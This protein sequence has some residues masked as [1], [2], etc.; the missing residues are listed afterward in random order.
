MF[1]P[2]GI[3]AA[4]IVDGVLDNV[5]Y[6]LGLRTSGDVNRAAVYAF[7]WGLTLT[8]VSAVLSPRPWAVGLVMFAIGLIIRI[9]PLFMLLP[10]Q[11]ERLSSLLVE[12]A[13]VNGAHAWGGGVA[14]YLIR[15][16]AAGISVTPSV[17]Q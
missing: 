12:L 8:F 14:L 11:R 16:L 15:K 2:A 7:A 17:Q 1:L 6:A 9:A 5:F 3:V 13:V 4:L 10:Y